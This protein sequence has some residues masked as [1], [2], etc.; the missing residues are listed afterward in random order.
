MMNLIFVLFVINSSNSF[1]TEKKKGRISPA[2]LNNYNIQ[3][4]D[5]LL[6]KTI[7]VLIP[8]LLP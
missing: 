2:F 3:L 7:P 1:F 5:Y 6:M 8:S 4:I